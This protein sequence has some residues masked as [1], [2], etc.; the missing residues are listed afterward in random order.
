[1]TG[2]GINEESDMIRQYIRECFTLRSACL[3]EGPFRMSSMLTQAKG[4]AKF[5]NLW[6]GEKLN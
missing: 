3:Q 2:Y 5:R 6:E 4:E 1:M